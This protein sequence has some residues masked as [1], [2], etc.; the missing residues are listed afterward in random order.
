M[1]RENSEAYNARILELE[2]GVF[3]PLVFPTS[4]GMLDEAKTLFKRVAAEMANKTSQQYSGT[5]TFIGKRLR[6]DLLKTTD[7]ALRSYS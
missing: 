5:I 3:S 2:K 6:Y 1:S 7:I 4:G